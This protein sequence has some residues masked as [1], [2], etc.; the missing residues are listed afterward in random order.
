MNP[1]IKSCS[2]QP[3]TQKILQRH[4]GIVVIPHKLGSETLPL[5]FLDL[6]QNSNS[7]APHT[8]KNRKILN[9]HS[10]GRAKKC[11]KMSQINKKITRNM[12]A[13]N[14]IWAH[15]GTLIQCALF[16]EILANSYKTLV[17]TGTGTHKTARFF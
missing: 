2:L 17:C 16:K 15:T 7:K 11:L 8:T 4:V 14:K 10:T 9:H 12:P 3:F 13:T 6:S 5:C 1:L